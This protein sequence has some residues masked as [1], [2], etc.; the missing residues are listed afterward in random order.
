M[1]GSI[2]WPVWGWTERTGRNSQRRTKRSDKSPN[3]SK[4]RYSSD[5]LDNNSWSGQAC[6]IT[7]S[8][9]QHDDCS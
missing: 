7:A 2:E 6:A 3:E 8:S 1:G 9:D 5:Q 4:S